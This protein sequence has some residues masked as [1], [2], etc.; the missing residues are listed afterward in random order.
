MWP[1][2]KSSGFFVHS[3]AYFIFYSVF[4]ETC[5]HM[6]ISG[7]ARYLCWSLTLILYSYWYCPIF[8]FLSKLITQNDSE[9]RS[10][11][12]GALSLLLFCSL[13]HVM[14]LSLLITYRSGMNINENN[15]PSPTQWKIPRPTAATQPHY[16][17]SL[18]WPD[19]QNNECFHFFQLHIL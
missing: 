6:L 11:R 9:R 16:H 13:C 7:I 12:R 2:L 15:Q 18:H 3:V 8:R 14:Y 5:F 1:L 10:D 17:N 4:N 19:A